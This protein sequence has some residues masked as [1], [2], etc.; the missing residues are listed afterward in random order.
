MTE[1]KAKTQMDSR[2]REY[3]NPKK[4]HQILKTVFKFQK[5]VKNSEIQNQI[6]LDKPIILW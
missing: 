5:S 2:I 6:R 4:G 3:T 1:P